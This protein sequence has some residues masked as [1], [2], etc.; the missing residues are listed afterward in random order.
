MKN[1][2]LSK[3]AI[4]LL[5]LI[6]Q[7]SYNAY[8]IIKQL[9][10]MNTKWWFYIGDSTVYA[11]LKKLE[12]SGHIIGVTE[13]QGNMPDKTIY[14]ITEIGIS[15]LRESIQKI[16]KGMDYDINLFTLAVFF[17][18]VFTLQE[19]KQ[20]LEG[21]LKYLNKFVA[22]FDHYIMAL[23]KNIPPY[24]LANTQRMK[25]I[26]NAEIVGLNEILVSL[27]K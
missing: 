6:N 14:T 15:A 5:G 2:L 22:S 19:Q 21:R 13:K 9:N 18:D 3:P 11:T 7:K 20:I 17:I 23:P 26:V 12:K 1:K 27:D 25:G 4:M 10:L 16:C 24:H 8:E